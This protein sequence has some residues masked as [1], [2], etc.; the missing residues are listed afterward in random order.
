MAVRYALSRW[1][2]L[3]RYVDDGR[4]EIHNNAE[5]SLRTVA[6]GRKN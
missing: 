2:A 3:L 1:N 5:R 4:I 6:L